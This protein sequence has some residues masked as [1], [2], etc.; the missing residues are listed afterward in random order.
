MITGIPHSLP[1]ESWL[2]KCK[3][4]MVNKPFGKFCWK[5]FLSW[6]EWHLCSWFIY[7]EALPSQPQ[8]STPQ[9]FSWACSLCQHGPSP[10]RPMCRLQQLCQL[11]ALSGFPQAH[12]IP[13]AVGTILCKAAPAKDT[14]HNDV[15]SSLWPT[16]LG[17]QEEE[18]ASLGHGFPSTAAALH[19]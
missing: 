4:C 18:S 15:N 6:V 10:R 11:T 8:F 12:R 3:I 1:R 13:E 19:T 16:C 7:R 17:R 5:Y 9:T 2:L 14:V